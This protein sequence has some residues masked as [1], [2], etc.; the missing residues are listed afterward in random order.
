M[1]LPP[2]DLVFVGIQLGV[3][4][5]QVGLLRDPEKPSLRFALSQAVLMG[6]NGGALATLGMWLSA[7][8]SMLIA[9]TWLVVCWQVRR[10]RPLASV[11]NL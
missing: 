7:V 8:G 10:V 9:L 1:G 6:I 5:S 2:Q 4:G 3:I 11:K